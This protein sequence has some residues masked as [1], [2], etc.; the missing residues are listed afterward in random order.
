VHKAFVPW[1]PVKQRG[2]R[3]QHGAVPRIMQRHLADEPAQP[4]LTHALFDQANQ[5]MPVNTVNPYSPDRPMIWRQG[6]E[7]LV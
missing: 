7:I 2:R 5:D 3:S 1:H 4:V 6:D